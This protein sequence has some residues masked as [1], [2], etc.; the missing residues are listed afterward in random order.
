[1]VRIKAPRNHQLCVM[2]II[3]MIVLVNIPFGI[4]GLLLLRSANKDHHIGKMDLAVAKEN[5]SSN[6][7]KAWLAIIIGGYI[8]FL[9]NGGSHF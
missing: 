6:L 2:T 1:M 5:I 8:V 4:I 9:L 7:M 3:S